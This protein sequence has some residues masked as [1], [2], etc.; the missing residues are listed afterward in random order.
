MSTLKKIP[1]HTGT[2][3]KSW[4]KKYSSNHPGFRDSI[5]RWNSGMKLLNQLHFWVEAP[6][7]QGSSSSIL[8]VHSGYCYPWNTGIP[9]VP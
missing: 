6:L 9:T 8:A 2:R 4:D 3:N 5:P 1:V 7:I